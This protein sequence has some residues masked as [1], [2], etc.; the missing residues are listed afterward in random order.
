MLPILLAQ[1]GVLER[2][3]PVDRDGLVGEVEERIRRVGGPVVVH[4]IRVRRGV[5]EH[6]E[7]V[8]D[9]ARHEDRRRRI[10]LG[11][12]HAPEAVARAQVDPGAED[13][14]RRDRHP[15]VPGLGV[16][17]SRRASGSVERDVV[18]HRAEVGQAQRRHLLALPVLLE[19]APVVAV[20]VEIEQ[21]HPRDGGL[22]HLHRHCPF[23]A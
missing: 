5:F 21:Q 14:A 16:D 4:Q 2:D 12:E 9:A 8:A 17:P 11:R 18:L 15:L 3:G 13:A 20:H 23:D 6:L 7:R 22:V 1:L 19:P 10:D